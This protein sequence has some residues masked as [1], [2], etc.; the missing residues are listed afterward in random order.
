MAS[1]TFSV[2]TQFGVSNGPTYSGSTSVAPAV[3]GNNTDLY[4]FNVPHG[5]SPLVVDANALPSTARFG[6]LGFQCQL[7]A[8]NANVS[9]P[10]LTVKLT[11]AGPTDSD[12]SYTLSPGQSVAFTNNNFLT[13]VWTGITVTPDATSDLFL[14]GILVT[15]NP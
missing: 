3:N 8:L 4:A 5:A 7:V 6:G 10:S 15:Q 11:G 9:T 1:Q 14:N 12:L 2:V 13:G